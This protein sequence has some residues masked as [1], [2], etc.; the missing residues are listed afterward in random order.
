MSVCAVVP[1][2]GRGTRLGLDRPKILAPLTA[3]ETIWSVLRAKLLAVADRVHVVVAPD[4]LAAM[5]AATRDD[6]DA[7]RLSLSVQERPTGMGDAI[8]G[9]HD[10]WRDATTLLVVWGDQVFV[11]DATLRAAVG[12]HGGAARRLVLP[13]VSLP[14]PYVEYVF[15]PGGGLDGVRQTR[16]GDRCAPGG[17]GDVGTFALSPCGLAGAWRDY[18]AGAARGA[19]TGE[20]NFLPFLPFLAAAGWAVEPLMVADAREARGVNTPDDL[21]YFRNL[22]GGRGQ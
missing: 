12:R 2:A 3:S 7:G 20:V 14:E 9:C 16:E 13:V 8:F 6:P 15:A 1:A 21:A 4:G 19:R 11:S 18:R 22:Q 17:L 10:A 5:R